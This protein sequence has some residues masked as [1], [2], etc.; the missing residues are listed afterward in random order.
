MHKRENVLILIKTVTFKMVS[1]LLTFVLAWGATGSATTGGIV[2][3]S[4]GILGIIWYAVH[5]KIWVIIRRNVRVA[6]WLE[7]TAHN[8]LVGGSS[9]SSH[10][11]TL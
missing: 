5:E 6:Q 9:P 11:K 10:T 7:P 1:S 3:I 8:G 2:A 4:R